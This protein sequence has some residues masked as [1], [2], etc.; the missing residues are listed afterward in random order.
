[1]RAVLAAHVETN[2]V[3]RIE[4]MRPVQ[5]IAQDDEAIVVY[6]RPTVTRGDSQ[7]VVEG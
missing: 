5:V 4:N 6:D 2:L 3:G 1:M 7:T